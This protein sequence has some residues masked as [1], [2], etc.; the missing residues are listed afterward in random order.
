MRKHSPKIIINPTGGLANRMRAL[1]AGI[2]LARELNCDYKVIWYRN[3]EL[4]ASM[5][6]IFELTDEL[7]ER[8]VYPS[9]LT[10]STIYSVP[11]KR[12]LYITAITSRLFFGEVLRDDMTE[13]LPLLD[14]DYAI[15]KSL[16]EDSLSTSRDF[17]MQGGI[18]MYPYSTELYRSLFKPSQQIQQKVDDLMRCL[19]GQAIGIHIRRADNFKSI[20]HSPDELFI[21]EMDAAIRSNPDVCF[22]LATDDESTKVKF[23]DLYG[24]RLFHSHSKAERGN[25]EG[26]IAAAVEMYILSRTDRIIGSHYSSF[27]EAAATLGGKTLSQIYTE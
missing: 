5:E 14:G 24:D 9:P 21:Q 23:K 19:N 7:K 2:S 20:Q 15:V 10:Y 26:I 17:L 13:L 4:N 18:I 1:A 27:S 25:M 22:Y 8:I 11:R 12:N 3:W 16:A 6:D